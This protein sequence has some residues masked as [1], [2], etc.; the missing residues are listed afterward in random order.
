MQDDIL[1]LATAAPVI[2][3]LV[4]VIGGAAPAL[5][6]RLYPAVAVALGIA[7]ALAVESANGDLGWH[8][9]VEGVVVGLTASGLYSGAV[10]PLGETAR[11]S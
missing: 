2:T 6:R 7:W 8:A 11:R 10:K 3:A 9:L 1:T 4:A 5:P